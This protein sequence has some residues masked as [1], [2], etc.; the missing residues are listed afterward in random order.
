GYSLVSK[1]FRVNTRKQ[2]TEETYHITFDES[3]DAIKFSKPSVD[4]I[5]I[6]ESERYPPDEY[7]HHY[8]PSQKYQVNINEVS[9]IDPYERSDQS[10]QSD[11]NDHPAQEN[12][13][14]NNN[15]YGH[16]NHNNDSHIIEN[17]INAEAVQDSEPTS[18][19]VEDAL[20][21]NIIP[22]PNIN[23]SSIPSA[24]SLV[25]QD[26]WSQNK[27]IKLVNIIGDLG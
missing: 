19:L 12:D 22:I 9:F 2:Q 26:R 23:L 3:I 15:P 5:N 25:A 20:T 13:I 17:I 16:S 24:I 1:A 11:Q 21:Q 8:E 18:S 27:H 7:L 6:A 14:P 4:N 10:N